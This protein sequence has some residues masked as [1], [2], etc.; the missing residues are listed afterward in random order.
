MHYTKAITFHLITHYDITLSDVM[1]WNQWYSQLDCDV[2]A[3]NVIMWNSCS[4]IDQVKYS[5]ES[6][7]IL[8]LLSNI[9][10][11]NTGTKPICSYTRFFI[12]MT[13]K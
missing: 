4:N 12:K 1:F 2:T 13:Q 8:F 5:A 3:S 7:Y 10:I 11:Q 9:P 6:Q